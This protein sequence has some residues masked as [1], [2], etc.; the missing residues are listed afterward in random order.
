[1]LLLLFL[2]F[3]VICLGGVGRFFLFIHRQSSVLD[4]LRRALHVLYV[5]HT[6]L[7]LV[8]LEVKRGKLEAINLFI[9]VN[10]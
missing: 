8:R 2:R 5:V 10:N 9:C 7:T 4:L 6:D 3:H 1:M